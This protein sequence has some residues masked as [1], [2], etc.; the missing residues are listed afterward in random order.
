MA[1]SARGL[2]LYLQGSLK[3][4]TIPQ[5]P[6]EVENIMDDGMDAQSVTAYFRGFVEG[7]LSEFRIMSKLKGESNVVSC[8]DYIV[9]PHTDGVR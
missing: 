8:E 3:T 5:S 2:R 9:V 1:H 6:A 4:V 7:L